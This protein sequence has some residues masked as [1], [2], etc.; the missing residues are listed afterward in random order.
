VTLLC[1]ASLRGL[2]VIPLKGPKVIG[3]R[4]ESVIGFERNR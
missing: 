1:H 3:F 4:A 2:G